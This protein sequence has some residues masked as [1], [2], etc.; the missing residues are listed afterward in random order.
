[1]ASLLGAGPSSAA[2]IPVTTESD[3][4]ADDGLCSLREAT[5]AANN[6]IAT[7]GCPAGSG[8]DTITLDAGVYALH[9]SGG[10]E[11]AGDLDLV[12]AT[13]VGKPCACATAALASASAARPPR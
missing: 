1:V 4:R 5:I 6:D 11:E 8:A 2:T 9:L 3:T 13:T 10:G 7:T 12:G